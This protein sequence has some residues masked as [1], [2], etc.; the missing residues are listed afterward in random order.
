[1]D[2]KDRC[3]GVLGWWI[4]GGGRLEGPLPRHKKKRTRGIFA[5][6]PL[7]AWSIEVAMGVALSR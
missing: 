7:A 3:G 4:P 2:Q 1:M 5:G 6:K